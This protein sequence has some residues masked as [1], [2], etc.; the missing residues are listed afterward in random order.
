M[1]QTTIAEAVKHWRAF[2][3]LSQR[4]LA[5]RADVGQV[6]IA[7]LELGQTDPRLSTLVKLTDALGIQM[8]DLFTELK[9]PARKRAGTGRR[10]AAE[11]LKK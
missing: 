7:R 2:R 9:R 5:E 1:R 11:G 4:D 10:Q 3:G 6:L 8:V